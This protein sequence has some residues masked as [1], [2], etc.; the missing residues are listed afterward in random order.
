MHTQLAKV[1]LDGC[2]LAVAKDPW[3]WFITCNI[4]ENPQTNSIELVPI[5]DK[6]Y[7]KAISISPKR[8]RI[9]S[10][11]TL[12]ARRDPIDVCIGSYFFA[13][14]RQVACDWGWIPRG[15]SDTH[16]L[17]SVGLCTCSEFPFRYFCW[18][19]NSGS[20]LGFQVFRT[21]DRG[22]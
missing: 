6:Q 9:V 4:P 3:N 11:T 17:S 1:E 13:I 20:E 15:I 16:F 21:H 22:K 2:F 18:P 19:M 14:V 5:A 12:A 10:W 7:P 8:S